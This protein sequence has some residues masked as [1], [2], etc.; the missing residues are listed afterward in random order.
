M[1]DGIDW[2][3]LGGKRRD[4][5]GDQWTAIYEKYALERVKLIEAI[6]KA[7][8]RSTFG[9]IEERSRVMGKAFMPPSH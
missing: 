7:T 1:N 8:R 9:P 5:E 3:R 2:S 6:A 4:G